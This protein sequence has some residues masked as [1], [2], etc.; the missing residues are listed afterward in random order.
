MEAKE[1]R[2]LFNEL[3]N[4]G[5][6]MERRDRLQQPYISEEMYFVDIKR[7]YLNTSPPL[8]DEEKFVERALNRI[9]THK[10]IFK[11][12]ELLKEFWYYGKEYATCYSS[13][14]E[15][16]RIELKDRLEDVKLFDEMLSHPKQEDEKELKQYPLP[17]PMEA[18]KKAQ[19]L[20][21]PDYIDWHLAKEK[22]L[23]P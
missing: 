6:D 10:L 3:I 13:D 17:R 4:A 20:D 11:I 19:E 12:R 18:W 21:L 23:K 2:E 5:R 8:T 7:R 14:G 15:C 9:S 1:L 22:S 16:E